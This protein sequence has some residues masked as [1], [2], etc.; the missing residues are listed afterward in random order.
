MGLRSFTSVTNTAGESKEEWD[1]GRADACLSFAVD[2]GSGQCVLRA[3]KF[4]D[5]ARLN[6]MG[7]YEM[8]G[9]TCII[10]GNYAGLTPKSV[11]DRPG[12]NFDLEHKV[13]RWGET[14][15]IGPTSWGLLQHGFTCGSGTHCVARWGSASGKRRARGWDTHFAGYMYCSLGSGQGTRVYCH[16]CCRK[17]HYGVPRHYALSCA[18]TSEYMGYI[19]DQGDFLSC[20]AGQAPMGGGAEC[21]SPGGIA[22]CIPKCYIDEA[23]GACIVSSTGDRSEHDGSEGT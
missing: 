8:S 1:Y 11:Y 5:A 15:A 7:L 6:W 9:S 16:D 19:G 22:E 3:T 23:S 13:P 20:P 10:G 4:C 12:S 21:H 17:Y 2:V 18:A 14:G